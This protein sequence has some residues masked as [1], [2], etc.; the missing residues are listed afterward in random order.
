MSA[1]QDASAHGDG[2]DD[3]AVH[4]HISPVNFYLA[5]FG[6]L[7]FFTLLTVGLSYVHLGPLNLAIAILIASMKAALVVVF[8]MHLN[9]DN[10]FNAV[11]F[12]GGLLFIGVFFAYT[13]NDTDRRQDELNDASGNHVY[14]GEA[15][16]KQAPGG[17]VPKETAESAEG[18]P[19]AGD[20]A[21]EHGGPA[22]PAHH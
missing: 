1:Y 20:H 10:R 8:F 19:G 3:G 7:I 4:S 13:L 17:F 14:L 21:P 6:A 5:I 2:H 22:A 11:A 15:D 16:E 9:H 18:Q 12:V